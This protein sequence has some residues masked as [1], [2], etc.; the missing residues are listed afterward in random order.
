MTSEA[1]NRKRFVSYDPVC[2]VLRAEF[3]PH[4]D[5]PDGENELFSIWL[6]PGERH[7]AAI[8]IHQFSSVLAKSRTL[9]AMLRFIIEVI[10]IQISDEDIRETRKELLNMLEGRWPTVR[11]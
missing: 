2:N 8:H 5:I 11:E 10:G 6:T 1:T 3:L 9:Q 4:G 7:I